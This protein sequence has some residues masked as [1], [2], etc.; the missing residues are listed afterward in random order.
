MPLLYCNLEGVDEFN[1]VLKKY[2]QTTNRSVAEICNAKAYFIDLRWMNEIPKADAQTIINK[3]RAMS[4]KYSNVPFE[5]IFINW[6]LGKQGKKGL[7]GQKMINAIQKLED[8][9]RK[10]IGFL[11][12]GCIPALRDLNNERRLG[13]IQFVKSNMNGLKQPVGIKQYG[14]KKGYVIPARPTDTQPFCEVG[15]TTGAEGDQAN[16]HS[17]AGD[18]K[19]NALRIAFNKEMIS[20]VDYIERK[21]QAGVKKLNSEIG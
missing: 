7:T 10:N 15:N 16:S 8:R 5:A 3:W 2:T 12:S 11:K 20:M 9:S 18:L 1:E 19:Q 21:L 13:N 6:K 4:K 14:K 17:E